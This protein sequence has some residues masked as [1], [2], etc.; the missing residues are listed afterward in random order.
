[1]SNGFPL[2]SGDTNK[3]ITVCTWVRPENTTNWGYI[4]S[5]GF[6]GASA[7]EL[8]YILYISGGRV[9]L[10]LGTGDGTTYEGGQH[11]SQLSLDIWY[12]ICAS[13]DDS[14][15]AYR[16]RIWDDNAGAILGTDKTGTI[17]STLY[18]GSKP[19]SIGSGYSGYHYFDGRLDKMMVFNNSLNTTYMDEVRTAV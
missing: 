8:S 12:F 5:K 6:R 13:Y 9:S 17:S 16:I 14:T 1:L 10:E 7:E 18:V 15:R 3:K 2:K 4:Y 19:V 11:S